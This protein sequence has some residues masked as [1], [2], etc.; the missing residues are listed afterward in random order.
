MNSALFLKAYWKFIESYLKIK[1]MKLKEYQIKSVEKL[2]ST[3]KNFLN[4][5]G[6]RTCV[7]KAPT[8]SGKTIMIAEWLSLFARNSCQ[9]ICLSGLVATIYTNKVG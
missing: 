5:G 3:S 8:G 9:E 1:N 4:K 2:L 7:I 6:V